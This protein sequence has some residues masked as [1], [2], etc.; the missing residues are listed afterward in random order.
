MQTYSMVFNVR[1]SRGGLRSFIQ[2]LWI[3]VRAG[4]F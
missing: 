4:A 1:L 3:S 2:L